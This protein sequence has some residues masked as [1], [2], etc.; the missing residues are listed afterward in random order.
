[1]RSTT[2]SST[3][4]SIRTV[5]LDEAIAVADSLAAVP[6]EAFEL[7]KRQLREP[8]PRQR[9]RDRAPATM[10]ESSRSVGG[11]GGDGRGPRLCRA[12]VEAVT[13][14]RRNAK[15]QPSLAG[16]ASF[17]LA[18][19]EPSR[20]LRSS[21]RCGVKSRAMETHVKVLGALQIALGACGLIG[22]LLLVFAFGGVAGIVGASGDPDASIVV[23][24]IGLTGMALV[25]VLLVMSLPSVIIGVGLVPCASPGRGSPASSSRSSC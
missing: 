10:R 20:P 6:F 3:P 4:S 5:L 14:V 11:G 17:G 8:A 12:D 16:H 21:P 22:A 24:I 13:H 25:S 15:H 7:T 18:G 1:M 2:A 23:P 19:A 9:M